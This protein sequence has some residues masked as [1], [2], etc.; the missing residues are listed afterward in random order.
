MNV[1]SEF[2]GVIDRSNRL[3][4]NGQNGYSSSA[5]P[6]KKRPVIYD[7]YDRPM[8]AS[9]SLYQSFGGYRAAEN[10]RLTQHLPTI[11]RPTNEELKYGV[12]SV[13]RARSRYVFKNHGHAHGVINKI[14]RRVAGRG[15][16]INA[17]M[18]GAGGVR[19]R[20]DNKALEFVF[21]AVAKDM[22]TSGMSFRALRKLIL[23]SFL[24]DG[25]FIAVKRT[26]ARKRIQAGQ[27]ILPYSR[28]WQ[29]IGSDQ[30]VED[31]T[32]Q[33]LEGVKEGNRVILGVEV[34]R[35][36]RAVA[37]HFYDDGG[38]IYSTFGQRK[39]RRVS[40]A[41]VIHWFVKYHDSQVRGLPTLTPVLLNLADLEEYIKATMTQAWVQACATAFIKSN[42]PAELQQMFAD[43]VGIADLARWLTGVDW[44]RTDMNPG[45]MVFLDPMTDVTFADPKSPPTQF[46]SF[47][48]AILRAIA[49]GV[50]ISYEA[51]ASDYTKTNFSSG[52]QTGNEDQFTYN[53]IGEDQDTHTLDPI[54]EDFAAHVYFVHRLLPVPDGVIDPYEHEV[55]HPRKEWVDPWKKARADTEALKNGT[56]SPQQ[57]C[58]EEGRDFYDV[59]TES[60][61]AEVFIKEEREK[62][63]LS[64]GDPG[65]AAQEVA[66]TN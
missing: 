47:T 19:L 1:S 57:V 40:A 2:R 27:E 9:S 35:G 56:K 62:R 3:N 43:E 38:D 31:K 34:D 29:V 48:E 5:S 52:Q 44:T 7:Q 23:H 24:E 50:G 16:W 14:T 25:E 59:A 13:L 32:A 63:G 60:I 64:V 33:E 61:E 36:G 49:A 15:T 18:Q 37:Y 8:R 20:A 55:Q 6:P 54:W 11:C 21:K 26:N 17:K 39:I 4:R 66:A 45:E 42:M 51:L 58:A 10:N 30:M 28:E 46:D 53:D 65:E 12:L 22:T 41:Q